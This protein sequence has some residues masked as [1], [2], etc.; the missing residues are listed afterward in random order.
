VNNKYKTILADPPWR[1]SNRTGKASPEHK[2]LSRYNTM[3][4]QDILDMKGFINDLSEDDCHL[5]M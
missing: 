2:R 3:S 4:L 5:W 1:Y